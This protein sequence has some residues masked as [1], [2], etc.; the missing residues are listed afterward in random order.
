MNKKKIIN[1]ARVIAVIVTITSIYLFAPWQYGLYYLEPLPATIAD[2]LT[3]ATANHGADGVIVYVNRGGKSS[4]FY[5]GGWFDRAAKISAEPHA[6][7]KIA[8]IGKLYD[9]AAVTKLVGAGDLDLDKTLADYLPDLVGRIEYADQITIRMMVMHRSG[10]PNFTDQPEYNWAESSLD[11][12]EMVLD[13]PALFVPGTDYSYSNTNYLLLTRIIE[14]I[15]G[16][17]Y[18]QYAREVILQPLGLEQTYFSVHEIN[19]DNLMSGYYVGHPD[20]FKALNQGMVA[21]AED[22]GIFLR[23]LIDGTLFSDEEQ[24]IYSAI[25]EYEHT[26]WVLGYQSVARYHQDI[27]AVVIMF[28]STTGGETILLRDVIYSRVMDII[29]TQG[30]ETS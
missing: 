22:V 15:V 9:A 12:L 7:F 1:I 24:G 26:G 20:D 10:I 2:E 19:L 21:T 11:V 4:D 14:S 6:L 18:A 23:A 29:R 16:Y 17:P 28:L 27:D 25:Y 8:S 13:K 5:A 3:D 30:E